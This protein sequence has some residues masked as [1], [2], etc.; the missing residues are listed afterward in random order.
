MEESGEDLDTR[1]LSKS[2]QHEGIKIKEGMTSHVFS[3]ECGQYY[4]RLFHDNIVGNKGSHSDEVAGVCMFEIDKVDWTSMN[5]APTLLEELV[6][7]FGK[8]RILRK[9]EIK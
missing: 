9:K 6:Q 5:L 7:V 1:F 2:V 8:E 4:L 3:I